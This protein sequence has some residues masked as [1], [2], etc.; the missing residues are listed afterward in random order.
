MALD[1]CWWG[2][3][4][5]PEGKPASLSFAGIC[6]RFDGANHFK[7]LETLADPQ[8]VL[9]TGVSRHALSRTR[10]WLVIVTFGSRLLVVASKCHNK[11]RQR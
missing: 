8:G 9:G 11:A 4:R 6:C 10:C 1:C 3:V 7:I 5:G 2:A